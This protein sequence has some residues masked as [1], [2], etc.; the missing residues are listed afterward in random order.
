[1]TIEQ[2]MLN[3]I[4]ERKSIGQKVESVNAKWGVI[5]PETER[6]KIQA[7]IEELDLIETVLLETMEEYDSDINESTPNMP[8]V[9]KKR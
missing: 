4:R 6:V 2:E 5:L 7:R 1:M 8:V 3:W 9:E